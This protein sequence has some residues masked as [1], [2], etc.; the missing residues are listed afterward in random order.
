MRICIK[1]RLA[2]NEGGTTPTL[3]GISFH[4]GVIALPLFSMRPME[5]EYYAH[6][7]LACKVSLLYLA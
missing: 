2:P 3:V 4:H 1:I 5:Q 6:K 7:A